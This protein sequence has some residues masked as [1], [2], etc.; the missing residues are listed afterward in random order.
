MKRYL[1]VL[2]TAIMLMSVAIT[3]SA[4]ESV[5]VS[6]EFDDFR[7][8][9][10]TVQ[11]VP[12]YDATGYEDSVC[13]RVW[14]QAQK[15][16]VTVVDIPL[17]VDETYRISMM[18]RSDT[19]ETTVEPFF[20][21]PESGQYKFFDKQNIGKKWTNIEFEFY[22]DGKSDKGNPVTASEAKLNLRT[23]DP[24][25]KSAIYIDNFYV[26]AKGD[27]FVPEPEAESAYEKPD[28]GKRRTI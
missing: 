7:R 16:N 19:G 10:I 21:F 6:Y 27:V 3:V 12:Y 22:F 24:T 15:N 14:P 4:A 13:L 25:T 23:Y 28:W 26:Y 18:M 2:M 1:A 8:G 20:T 9:G 5:V 17:L 11:G